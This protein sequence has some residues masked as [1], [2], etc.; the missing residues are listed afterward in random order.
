MQLKEKPLGS[1]PISNGKR[2]AN[3]SSQ[4]VGR[5]P[6]MGSRPLDGVTIYPRGHD[7]SKGSRPI[8]GVTTH[9]RGHDPFVGSRPLHGVTTQ[10]EGE[11]DELEM[12]YFG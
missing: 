11:V 1:R 3:K 4:F 9:P 12:D 7:P 2:I 8:Q 6:W 5:N 10:I